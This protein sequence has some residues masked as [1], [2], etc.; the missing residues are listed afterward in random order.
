VCAKNLEKSSKNSTIMHSA[1]LKQSVAMRS[2]ASKLLLGGQFTIK[3]LP[4]IEKPV[5]TKLSKKKKK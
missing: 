2:D 5:P 1:E 3:A 4:P